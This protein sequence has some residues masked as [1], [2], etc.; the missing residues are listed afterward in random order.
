MHP[1]VL[2]ESYLANVAAA[3][4]QIGETPD[5]RELMRMAESVSANFPGLTSRVAVELRRLT[6][7]P[8][9]NAGRK[10]R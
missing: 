8:V 1:M 7:Q 4:N 9:E 6:D 10:P 3:E 2:H 5:D